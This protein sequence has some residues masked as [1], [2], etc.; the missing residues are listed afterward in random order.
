MPDALN[1]QLGDHDALKLTIKGFP[2]RAFN[3]HRKFQ[4]LLT[5]RQ[6]ARLAGATTVCGL[7]FPENL[8]EQRTCMLNRTAYAVHLCTEYLQLAVLQWVNGAVCSAAPE[9]FRPSV[10]L[11]R[12]DHHD[13]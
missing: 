1:H 13:G 5:V 12:D 7:L 3:D 9:Y 11:H 6:V 4:L 10:G 2:H 8:A